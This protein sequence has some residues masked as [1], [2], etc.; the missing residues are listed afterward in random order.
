MEVWSAKWKKFLKNT[1]YDELKGEW[2]MHN[3][4]YLICTW[5]TSMNMSV[6]MLIESI[7]FMEGMYGVCQ[8]NLE[9]RMLQ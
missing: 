7:G 2:D 6:G 1:V 9:V 8:K 3:T 5:I 4:D